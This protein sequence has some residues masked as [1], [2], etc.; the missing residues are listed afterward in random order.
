MD[1]LVIYLHY[2]KSFQ[3]CQNPEKSVI[4]RIRLLFGHLSQ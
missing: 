2:P 4:V 1:D 3:Q